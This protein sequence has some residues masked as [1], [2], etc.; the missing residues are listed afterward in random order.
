MKTVIHIGPAKTASTSIQAIIPLLGRPYEIKPTWAKRLCRTKV[1]YFPRVEVPPGYIV[2][3]ELMGD[4][5]V[6]PPAV[7]ADR[8][9]KVFGSCTIVFIERDVEERIHSYFAQRKKNIPGDTMTLDQ[10]RATVRHV[11]KKGLGIYASADITK[12]RQDFGAHDLRVIP[13]DL[14]KADPR[15]FLSAFCDAC[16]A[17]VP[18]IDFPHLNQR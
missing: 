13:F 7:I 10:H 2:S 15:A 18:E 16:E 4:F 5:D 3:E 6:F 9:F 1:E 14:L 11:A 12:L 17:P 8:L